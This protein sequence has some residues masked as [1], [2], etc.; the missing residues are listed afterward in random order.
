MT[1]LRN[2][3]LFLLLFL[4]L[5]LAVSY[6]AGLLAGPAIIDGQLSE[7]APYPVLYWSVSVLMLVLPTVILV[8]GLHWLRRRGTGSAAMAAITA[9]GF[10]ALVIA[11]W[12]TGFFSW[13]VI[14]FVAL[15]ALAYGSTLKQPRAG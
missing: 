6:G 7:L 1:L 8:P 9:L 11:I 3:A 2:L 13:P 4:P 10:I 5:T 12:G 15:P 14:V